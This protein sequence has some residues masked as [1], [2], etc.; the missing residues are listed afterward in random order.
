MGSNHRWRWAAAAL[1]AVMYILPT[2]GMT[3]G[4]KSRSNQVL[5]VENLKKKTETAL[6]ILVK[7]WNIH[8]SPAI[9]KSLMQHPTLVQ[10]LHT[11]HPSDWFAQVG[12]IRKDR[13][14]Q[15]M[16]RHPLLFVK[17]I[18]STQL[19]SIRSFLTVTLNLTE[20]QWKKFSRVQLI[21]PRSHVRKTTRFLL[22]CM[23]PSQVA[24]V[25]LSRPRLFSYNTECLQEPVLYFRDEVRLTN[26]EISRMINIWPV[27][28]TFNVDTN[29]RPTVTFLQSLGSSDWDGW[30]RMI[31][32]YPQLLTHSVDGVL[33]PKLAFL[34]N[35]LLELHMHD[36]LMR[37]V[38]HYP[39]VFWLS[40]EILQLKVDYL[41]QT[42]KLS[43]EEIRGV[44]LTFPQILGLSIN[45]NLKPTIEFYST[46]LTKA[47]LKEF[48]LYQPSLLAYS[49][50]KRIRPRIELMNAKG[51]AFAYSPPYLMSLSDDKFQQW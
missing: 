20:T 48:F 40:P 2:R 17:A 15:M 38:S 7:D 31:V 19:V 14:V 21:W 33:R 51:I 30:K 35:T 11:Q 45:Y 29:L 3:A 27:I 32:R 41:K 5:L 9:R 4:T 44:L 16:E 26:E 1:V 28:L 12:R 13:L 23:N 49:L 43:S 36:S 34:E 25:I 6:E 42:L 8:P 39:P 18:T 10:A 22:E 50:E 46:C 37:I 24:K 47:E